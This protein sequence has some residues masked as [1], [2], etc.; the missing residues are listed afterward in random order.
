MYWTVACC[1][2]QEKVLEEKVISRVS[3]ETMIDA[4]QLGAV[5][6]EHMMETIQKEQLRP[7]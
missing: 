6:R 1:Q 3:V 7:W 2:I 4:T 5:G